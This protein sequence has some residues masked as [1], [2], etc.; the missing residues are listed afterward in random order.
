[1]TISLTLAGGMRHLTII[2]A[3]ALLMCCSANPALAVIEAL[4]PLKKFRADAT[5]IVSVK[6]EKLDLEKQTAVLTVE[7][8]IAGEFNSTRIPLRLAGDSDGHPTDMLDRLE[9]GQRLVL[10]VTETPGQS[11]GYAYTR[12]SWFQIIGTRDG[13]RV[14]WQFTH[15]EPYLRRTFHGETHELVKLLQSAKD[16]P[17]PEEKE[18]PGLG[19]KIDRA[20]EVIVEPELLPDVVAPPE[21]SGE[22]LVVSSKVTETIDNRPWY[23]FAATVVIG[24]AGIAYLRLRGG[25]A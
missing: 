9:A 10:F 2:L 24:L 4:T 5:A 18:K 25:P 20:A 23:V 7:K 12:G 14:L 11:I 16:L 19:A 22:P 13:E 3:T 8:L 21:S 15:A 1:V 6:V 17:E